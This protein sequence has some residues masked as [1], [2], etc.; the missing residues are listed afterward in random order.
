MVAGYHGLN[1][2]L[3]ELRRLCMLSAQGATLKAL[4]GAAAR[5]GLRARGFEGGPQHLEQL[6][7]PAILHWNAVHFVVLVSVERDLSDARRFRIHD[8]RA[9]VRT[10]EEAE[11]SSRFTGAVLELTRFDSPHAALLLQSTGARSDPPPRI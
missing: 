10:L 9:G 8:P 3:P 4:I 11:L 6:A 5:I 7:L 2:G 1:A